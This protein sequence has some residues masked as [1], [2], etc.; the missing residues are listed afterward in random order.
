M[1]WK[2]I[3]FLDFFTPKDFSISRSSVQT[4]ALGAS[5]FFGTEKKK[6]KSVLDLSVAKKLSKKKHPTQVRRIHWVSSEHI[7]RSMTHSDYMC[8]IYIL[9]MSD[10][11]TRV[12]TLSCVKY[13]GN[14]P[15]KACIKVRETVGYNRCVLLIKSTKKEKQYLLTAEKAS[16]ITLESRV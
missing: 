11:Q 16:T 10:L 8:S 3:D 1:G 13:V 7:E 2:I 12:K 6:E 14:Y 4:C 5:L 9:Q 15:R